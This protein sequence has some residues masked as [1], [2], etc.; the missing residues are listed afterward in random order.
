[1]RPIILVT[2]P[3]DPEALSTRKLVLESA[4]YNVLTAFTGEE[5]AE[6]AGRIPL[7]AAVIHARYQKADLPK[8][9][10]DLK[11]LRPAMPVIVVSPTPHPMPNA[12]H[13]LSSHDPLSLVNLVY[14]LLGAPDEHGDRIEEKSK[15]K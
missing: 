6:I 2:D 3:P 1:M 8:I 10:A 4:K 14:E 7:D 9:L 5:A 11:Q 12:D 15:K 13:V